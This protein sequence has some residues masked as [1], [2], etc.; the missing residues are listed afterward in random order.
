MIPQIENVEA[1]GVR[2]VSYR[3]DIGRTLRAKKTFEIT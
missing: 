1:E 3:S 2:S